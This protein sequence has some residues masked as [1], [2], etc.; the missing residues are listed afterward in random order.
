MGGS[1]EGF[2][3]VLWLCAKQRG[4]L[5]LHAAEPGHVDRVFWMDASNRRRDLRKVVDDDC[6][7]KF[8]P[9]GLR[10]MGSEGAIASA[11]HDVAG[12]GLPSKAMHGHHDVDSL[13][14]RLELGGLLRT[15]K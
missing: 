11:E 3:Q 6:A 1:C 14:K 5:Q 4:E 8:G 15:K 9:E 13:E 2:D 12:K 10:E 7:W